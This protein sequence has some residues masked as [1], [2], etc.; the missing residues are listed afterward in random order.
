M[1][2]VYRIDGI[3]SIIEQSELEAMP[4]AQKRHVLAV[5]REMTWQCYWEALDALETPFSE[6]I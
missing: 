6:A 2:Y 4:E 5:S 1:I 3:D